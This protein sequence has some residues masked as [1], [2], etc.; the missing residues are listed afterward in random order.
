MDHTQTM[1]LAEYA[2]RERHEQV[3]RAADRWHLVGDPAPAP[4]PR[5]ALAGALIALATWLAPERAAIGYGG[6][7]I[8]SPARH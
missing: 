3:C 2:A 5:E 8:T 6:S 7:A 4:T 1:M